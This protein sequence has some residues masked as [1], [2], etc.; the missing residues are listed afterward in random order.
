MSDNKSATKEIKVLGGRLVETKE[1]TRNGEPVGFVIGYMATWDV[2]S[3]GAFGVPDRF[4]QGAWTESLAEHRARGNRP[5]RLAD[6]HGRTIGGFP[7]EGVL[8]DSTGLFGIGEINLETQ[9]GRE[10]FSLAK[11]GVLSDFSVGFSVPA[12]GD[13]I[14]DGVRVINK[15]R[16]WETSIVDEPANQN[17]RILEV[18]NLTRFADLPVADQAIEWQGGQTV[19][20]EAFLFEGGPAI[21]CEIKGSLVVVP[22]ALVAAAEEVKSTDTLEPE[23]RAAAIRHLERYFAKAG[24]ASPFDVEERQFY[25]AA[26]V[27]DLSR[28]DFEA[29]LAK[30][31]AF[32][33]SAVTALAARLT[34]VATTGGDESRYSLG[35]LAES[36]R[37]TKE[38]LTSG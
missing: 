28:R 1:G 17:A 8:E 33:K 38:S 6:H 14:V 23:V 10:A 4:E 11:Q 5:V 27:K 13:E 25:G 31:G 15:A 2:D 16:L 37:D 34:D 7:I 21:A 24:I 22:A 30:T 18:K 29:A 26:E 36:I 20:S 19:S 12:G 9:Q 32:S 35:A 3:G